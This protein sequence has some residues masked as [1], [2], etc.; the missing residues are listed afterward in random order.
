M[1]RLQSPKMGDPSTFNGKVSPH[2]ALLI[3]QNSAIH[4]VMHVLHEAHRF[5]LDAGRD[6][7][8]FAVEITQLRRHG[9]RESHFRWLVCKGM[10]EHAEEVT[11]A[12]QNRRVFQRTGELTFTEST[13]FVVLQT[14]FEFSAD[15]LLDQPTIGFAISARNRIAEIESCLPTWDVDRHE[16]S[17]SGYLVK[18]F[19]HKSRNQETILAAFQ[20]EGWPSAIPDPLPQNGDTDPKRRLNDTIKGLNHHQENE[21]IRFRG[22]GTGEGVIWE[23]RSQRKC[24]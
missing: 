11:L 13:C 17:F 10:V 19:K 7:W 6:K 20:E 22:D 15:L 3:H 21:L 24:S 16:L 12:G 5:A 23:S 2:P 8:D 1:S 14:E 9:V 18:R 4:A